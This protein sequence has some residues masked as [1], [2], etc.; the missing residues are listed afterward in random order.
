MD[1][2]GHSY[3]KLQQ[4]VQPESRVKLA[5]VHRFCQWYLAA[6]LEDGVDLGDLTLPK[7]RFSKLTEHESWLDSFV[8]P[9]LLCPCYSLKYCIM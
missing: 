2:N 1:T 3:R 8:R 4:R 7:K 6:G 9:H 5:R